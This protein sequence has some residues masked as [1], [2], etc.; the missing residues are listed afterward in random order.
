[1]QVSEVSFNCSFKDFSMF[2]EVTSVAK[3]ETN[4][5]LVLTLFATT[6]RD[7][8]L[9]TPIIAGLD[10]LDVFVDKP[11]FST[12]LFL[13][14]MTKP[15]SED[16]GNKLELIIIIII[17]II[18]ITPWRRVLQK[19]VIAQLVSIFPAFHEP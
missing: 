4:S 6:Q 10:F 15:S 12:L 5:A 16:P 3:R 9:L 7:E 2:V 1:V 11:G 19:Q 14:T 13:T 8:E 17:I 18:I